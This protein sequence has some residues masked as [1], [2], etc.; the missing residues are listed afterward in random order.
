MEI[1]DKRGRGRDERGKEKKERESS[2]K[3]KLNKIK[4]MEYFV[5]NGAKKTILDRKVGLQMIFIL[6]LD[7]KS[8][9]C[10][11]TTNANRYLSDLH[12]C[13]SSVAS[14]VEK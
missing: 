7:C 11:S 1:Y 13:P 14:F 6:Y 5:R 9:Y 10:I 3:R 4:T 12:R 8:S 2:T